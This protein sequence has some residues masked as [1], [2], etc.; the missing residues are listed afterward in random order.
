VQV[1]TEV[2]GNDTQAFYKE[3]KA[4]LNN[5]GRTDCVVREGDWYGRVQNSQTSEFLGTYGENRRQNHTK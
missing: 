3:L 1:P 4:C 2:N 5:T